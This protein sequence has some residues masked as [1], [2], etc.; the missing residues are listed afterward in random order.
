MDLFYK[1]RNNVQF[2]NWDICIAS[3]GSYQL[4]GIYDSVDSCGVRQVHEHIDANRMCFALHP[5]VEVHRE[6]GHVATDVHSILGAQYVC[7]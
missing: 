7:D 1:A 6:C 4:V 2:G 5:H 3:C